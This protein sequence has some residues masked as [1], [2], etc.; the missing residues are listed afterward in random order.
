MPAVT[1]TLTD[2]PTGVSVHSD[3][4]P[5]IGAS[6]S[7]AQSA[8]LD[9]IRRTR[10]EWDGRSGHASCVKVPGGTL[11]MLKAYN[12]AHPDDVPS[13]VRHLIGLHVERDLAPGE[14][15]K[16]LVN[17]LGADS[18]D[19]VEITMALEDAFNIEVP[20]EESAPCATVADFTALVLRKLE[21][22][23]A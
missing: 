10:N 9:I 15:T 18:L 13:R 23:S 19:L 21:A 6:C 3:F 1:I 2:T 8:A 5:A 12:K 20:D 7:P 16:H 4:K 14:D 17:E 11:A 22:K